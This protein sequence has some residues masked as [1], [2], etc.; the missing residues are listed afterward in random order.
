MFLVHYPHWPTPWF[1]VSNKY[2]SL[3]SPSDLKSSNTS[4]QSVPI[5]KIEEF[6]KETAIREYKSQMKVTAPFLLTFVRKK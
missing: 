3:L 6:K 5:N 4:W 2:E 1:M